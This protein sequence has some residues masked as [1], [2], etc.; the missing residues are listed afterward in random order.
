MLVETQS[1]VMSVKNLRWR[2]RKYIDPIFETNKAIIDI[3]AMT[4]TK[5]HERE[6]EHLKLF[7]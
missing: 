7:S 1:T 4:K 2:D 5:E 3:V 6:L